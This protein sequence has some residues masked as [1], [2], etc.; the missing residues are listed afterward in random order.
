[1]ANCETRKQLI[2]EIRKLKELERYKFY[3]DNLSSQQM[4]HI[5]IIKI[6]ISR[7]KKDLKEN[8]K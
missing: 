2:K 4:R 5:E 6:K 3:E 7:L 8:E 1:M